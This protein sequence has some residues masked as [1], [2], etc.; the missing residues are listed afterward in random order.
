MSKTKHKD[1]QPW[2]DYYDMLHTYSAQGYLQI[3]GDKHEAYVTQPSL[4]AMSNGD[5][6]IVQMQDGSIEKT[7]RRLRTY[8]AWLSGGGEGY[9]RQPFAVHVV[10]ADEPH[11]LIF[12]VLLSWKRKLFRRHECMEIIMYPTK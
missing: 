6:P 11:D 8:A 4:H 7:V 5:D 9:L 2:L 3:E 10:Q 12:T 1:L